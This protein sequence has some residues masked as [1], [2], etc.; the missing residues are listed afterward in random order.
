MDVMLYKGGTISLV[1]DAYMFINNGYSGIYGVA[2]S[3]T[4]VSLQSQECLD[5]QLVTRLQ[6]NLVTF[7]GQ[8]I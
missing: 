6:Y 3:G 7:N 4:T 5:Q 2:S 8:F 1:Q